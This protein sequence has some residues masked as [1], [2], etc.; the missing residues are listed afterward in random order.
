MKNLV[1]VRSNEFQE[2]LRRKPCEDIPERLKA[3]DRALFESELMGSLP[4]LETRIALD[5]DLFR[6]HDQE[7]VETIAT[8]SQTAL[9]EDR[10]VQIFY[11]TFIC[12][13]S[14]DVA[15]LAAGSGLRAVDAV[16]RGD[17]KTSFVLCRPPGHHALADKGM[18]YCLFNNV[19]VAARYAQDTHNL[20]RVA[21]IDWDV[22]HGNGTQSIFYDDPSVLF[23]SIHEYPLFPKDSGWYTEDGAGDGRGFT[24]NIP[25]PIGN[26]DIGYL[27]VW[28]EIVAPVVQEFEPDL[29]LLSAG[30]DAHLDDPMGHQLVSIMGYVELSQ[31]LLKLADHVGLVAFL[32]GGYNMTALANSVTACL[33]VF[34]RPDEARENGSVPPAWLH[35]ENELTGN[36]SDDILHDRI[37]DTKRHYSRYWRALK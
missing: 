32:E 18:G 15:K 9:K 3:I 5:E 17:Y 26:G 13:T 31:R 6:A 2:H 4:E 37:K 22:H 30:F 34:N 28:D 24:V 7:Y 21:I 36:R 33:Q 1:I 25:L 29:I 35:G 10:L 23:V 20:K 12:S 27:T 19:A 8:H 14:Y 11:D 16:A